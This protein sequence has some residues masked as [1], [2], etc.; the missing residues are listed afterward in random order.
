MANPA[1]ILVLRTGADDPFKFL[2]E[3]RDPDGKSHHDVTLRH[4]TYRR[5]SGEKFAPETCVEAAFLFLLD[6]E[7]KGS[8]LSKFQIEQISDYFPEFE[9]AM[10]G[11]FPTV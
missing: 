7:P 5:L 6:R 1:K 4:E 8:I 10:P 9:Q 11:Y 2:V 3:V